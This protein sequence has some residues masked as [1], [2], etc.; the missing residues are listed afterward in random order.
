MQFIHGCATLLK[1]KEEILKIISE[2]PTEFG[3]FYT[4][5]FE[6]IYDFTKNKTGINTDTYLGDFKNE[7]DRIRFSV[8]FSDFTNIYPSGLGQGGRGF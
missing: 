8:V 1:M 3:N 4:K 6:K 2:Q 7:L 5:H